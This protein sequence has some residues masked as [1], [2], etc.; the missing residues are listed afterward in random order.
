MFKRLGA[1]ALLIST[2]AWALAG[3]GPVGRAT[4]AATIRYGEHGRQQVDFYRAAG[5]ARSPLVV[6][7]HGGG[8]SFGNRSFVQDKPAFV[9]GLGWSFA[10]A[11]YRVLPD[12]AVEEQARDVA[13]A[14]RMLRGDA[15]RLGIDPDRV[16]LMGHS[17][18]AHLAALLATDPAYLGDAFG[19]VRGVVLL[20]GAAYDAT[21]L[22]AAPGFAGRLYRRAFGA[23]PERQRRLSPVA[24]AAR[25][26]APNWLILYV[27]DRA[28]SGGQSR[29]LG[30]RLRGAGARV[31]VISVPDTDHGRINRELGRQGDPATAAVQRFLGRLSSE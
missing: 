25:P 13:A 30:E 2:P 18:G 23:D 24:H 27:A 26:D 19:S 14:V 22:D 7:V 29:L 6:F 9:T 16:V 21:G 8:W 5:A 4:P 28:R 11:G 20:D 15:A 17:A 12:A 31:E 10:S 3:Q 1:I